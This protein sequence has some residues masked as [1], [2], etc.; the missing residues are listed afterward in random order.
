MKNV[1]GFD[2]IARIVI[3]TVLIAYAVTSGAV[4]GYVGIVPLFTGLIGWC[5]AY[6]P[7]KISTANSCCSGNS[8]KSSEK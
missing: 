1:G 2:R 8:C 6:C 7:F 3:G 4:W 5:P